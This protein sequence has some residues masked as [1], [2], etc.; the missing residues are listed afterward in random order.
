MINLGDNHFKYCG[1]GLFT[2]D[3]VWIHPIRR[4]KTYEIIH[5]LEGTV[6]LFEE[7][8]KYIFTEGNTIILEKGLLHGGYLESPGKT[9]FFWIHFDIDDLSQFNLSGKV[10]ENFSSAYLFRRLLH[11]DNNR[12]CPPFTC[13]LLTAQL[14]C[15]ISFEQA[16]T[17]KHSKLVREVY[18]WTRINATNN[19][20]AGKVGE[21]FSY[22]AEHLSRL[23]KKEYNKGTKALICSFII[24]KAN[25]YL[26]NTNYS[27]KEIATL[28]EFPDSSAFINFYKYH[29]KTTPA[30]YRNKYNDVHMNKQ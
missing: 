10:L 27:V 19:L 24:E 2:T 25:N 12:S 28:L 5:I 9:S 13:D 17:C 23:L 18:E 1:G 16:N 22:N 15:E 26:S 6:Y 7:E 3:D 4:E 11:Y 30:A 20:T 21:H 8:E 14:L 29:Q